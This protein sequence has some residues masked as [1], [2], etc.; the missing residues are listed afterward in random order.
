ME[1]PVSNTP[2]TIGCVGMTHLGII[3]MVAFAEKGFNLIG[4]DN[5]A[6][7]I[8]ELQQHQFPVKEP[9]L[10]ALVNKNAKRLTFSNDL[11][12]L[13]Q[14]SLVFLACDVPTDHQ[15]TSN[16]DKIDSLIQD[17]LPILSTNA[18]FIILSQVPPGF[19]RKVNLPKAR[20]FYQ[21]ETL[22]FGC[23]ME[24][25]LHPERYIVGANDPNLP[26][27]PDYLA[28]LSS[29]NCPILP[30]QYE[31]AELCKISINMFL[32]ASV[33]TTN[34]IAEICE[35]IGAEWN[36]IAPALRL[37]K[38]IGPHAYLTPGLGIAGGNLE[39]DLN[40]IIQIGSQH[41]TDTGTVQA[42]I[43]NSQYRRD[44]V[45][46]SIQKLIHKNKLSNPCICILGLAYKPNTHSIKNSPAIALIRQL[47]NFDVSMH[48]HDPAVEEIM[49]KD[50]IQ[51]FTHINDALH[52]ADITIIMT[53]WD[54]YQQITASTLQNE[55]RK[56]II[57]D[58]FQVFKLISKE[59]IQAG[60]QYHTLGQKPQSS[61][62]TQVRDDVESCSHH[63]ETNAY[64]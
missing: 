40:T 60:F 29:F 27:P 36:E 32:V 53:P 42:W 62:P 56:K 37:D 61:H 58:P 31:S 12:A 8:Q 14:C 59:L 49:D 26:L 38:R 1:N 35:N 7:L 46:R 16:L 24:R 63:K 33:T 28:L 21:V 50:K 25:A 51:K 39:R 55:L 11:Q 44:W 18:C 20:L 54:D 57:I 3:H 6:E 34:T 13:S 9:Q 15:G 4:Y 17:T 47:Q 52:H 23:A 5:D 48:V 22:I 64:V 45:I 2:I 30:M 19:T 10:E 43:K 41:S